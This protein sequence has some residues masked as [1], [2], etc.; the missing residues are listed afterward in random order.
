MSERRGLD[1]AREAWALHDWQRCFDLAS[2]ETS[3]RPDG[4]DPLDGLTQAELL[5]LVADAAWWLGRL[6]VCIDAREQAYRIYDAAGDSTRAGQCAIW[7][8]EHHC[9]RASPSV[10]SGWLG[11]AR[12]A[13]GKSGDCVEVGALVL[14]EAEMAHGVGSL[15]SAA[16]LAERG[17]E[18]G[19]HL[20]CVDLEAEALQA[21]GRIRIDQG[22]TAEGLGLL[23]EAMLFAVEDRLSPYSTG[24][25]YCSLISACE[26]LS[27]HR[28]AAEWTAATS[29][30]ATRH[31]RAVFPGLCRVHHA[32]SLRWRGKL[33][34]AE[35]EAGRACEEL[36]GINLPNA[37]AAFA[38]IGDIRRR[39]G[40]LV[41]AAEAFASA[42]RLSPQPRAGVALLRLAQ[43][44]LDAASTI[45]GEALEVA[46]WNRLARAKMLPALAQISIATGDLGAAAAAVEE[47]ETT[48]AE[49]DS[50]GLEAAGLS[51]RGRLQ[52]A[53]ESTAAGATLRSAVA[54]WTEL[55]VPYEMATARMLLGEAH[56]RTGDEGAAAADFAAARQLFDD[57]GVHVDGRGSELRRMTAERPDGLTEREVEVLRLVAAGKTNKQVAATLHLSDKT[58]AR[59][60]S[61]IFTKI[62][63]STRTAATA[64]AFEHGLV[65]TP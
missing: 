22:R 49:F 52:I 16:D 12:R 29:R 34:E 9:F 59:H 44:D 57:L 43:G 1:A 36:A 60:L 25:V 31:P 63:V 33:A 32:T 26:E 37:S 27:D 61:N 18:L 19:R 38:E 8:Y 51:A 6:D 39:L 41:G 46:G 35:R 5:D 54:R 10:A 30:W 3:A 50:R 11:R 23:D 40:D 55:G 4:S 42:D 24:K 47:L 20:R 62:G 48:A 15:D 13:L 53:T 28:R 7:L 17:L 56:R 21:L 45:A 65:R 2:E 64:F 58:I 14:R